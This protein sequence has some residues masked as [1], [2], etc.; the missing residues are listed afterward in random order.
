VW[1][2]LLIS[3]AAMFLAELGDKTQLMVLTLS[4]KSGTPFAVFLG[5]AAALVAA[6]ALAT[7]VGFVFAK[8]LPKNVIEVTA[9]VLFIGIGAF[10]I[11]GQLRG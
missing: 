3:F 10:I 5:A 11:Y 2:T 1:K 7:I 8:A 9:G 4:A 6:T